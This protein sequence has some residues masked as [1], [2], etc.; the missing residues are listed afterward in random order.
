MD[1]VAE[2]MWWMWKL[3]DNVVLAP[4]DLNTILLKLLHDLF[5]RLDSSKEL[6]LLFFFLVIE[7]S[8][9]GSFGQC[10]LRCASSGSLVCDPY[11]HNPFAGILPKEPEVQLVIYPRLFHSGSESSVIGALNA[12]L[13]LE[14][15]DGPSASMPS[16]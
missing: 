4:L 5:N 16:I 3:Q 6:I 14:S 2:G 10:H 12:L 1:Q 7:E 8:G 11:V 13:V 9:L 15:D